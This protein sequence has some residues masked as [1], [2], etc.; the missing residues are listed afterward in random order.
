MA[1]NDVCKKLRKESGRKTYG[2][3]DRIS[4]NIPKYIDQCT[5]DFI[6]SQRLI[7]NKIWELVMKAAHD[8]IGQVN[9]RSILKA[10]G[11]E[12]IEALNGLLQNSQNTNQHSINLKGSEENPKVTEIEKLN[13]KGE[14]NDVKEK[15]KDNETICTE[16]VI[17]EPKGK[18]GNEV[19]IAKEKEQIA[20]KSVEVNNDSEEMYR[21]DGHMNLKAIAN[22]TGGARRGLS[23][24]TE[25]S[26]LNSDKP[27]RM[28]IE[29]FGEK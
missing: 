26:Q 24:N 17:K 11:V 23:R 19:L 18:N 15:N 21:D 14:L 16:E 13:P 27:N 25:R 29:M 8:E 28:E 9:S 12:N 1:N 5:L 7:A 10:L 6:N 2:Y 3:G 4:I 20:E 22:K